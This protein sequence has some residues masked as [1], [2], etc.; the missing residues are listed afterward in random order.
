MPKISEKKKK[1]Y[2]TYQTNKK[3]TYVSYQTDSV[4]IITKIIYK[5]TVKTILQKNL[6]H[7]QILKNKKIVYLELLQLVH[8]ETIPFTKLVVFFF[9]LY[10][11]FLSKQ[12]LF[13]IL[14]RIIIDD[15]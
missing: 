5:F 12:F 2:V 8:K 10:L 14:H 6:H 1:L 4:E 7:T 3:I 13:N 9:F 11:I 15:Y